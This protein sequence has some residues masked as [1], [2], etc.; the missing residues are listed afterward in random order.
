M[1]DPRSPLQIAEQGYFFA[2]GSYVEHEGAT[3]HAG[4]MFVQYQIPAARTQPL[5]IVMIHGGS[6][7]GTNFLGTPDGRPGWADYFLREGYAVYV[8][9]QPG[10]ARS[11]YYPAIY[12]NTRRQTVAAAERRF[13]APA[14]TKLWPQAHLHTQ[15]PGTGQ[16]G[17]PVFDQFFASQVESIDNGELTERLAR[18]AGVSLFER[19]GAAILLTHSQSGPFG[20]AI[21][22]A[23]PQ[24]VKAILSIEPNGPP[25]HELD[26]LGAPQWFEDAART[27]TW[28][29]TRVPLTYDPPANDPAALRFVK[30]AAADAPGLARCWL[31]AEPARKLPR[32][33]GIPI[34]ILTSEASYH[35]AY[36]HG[37]SR[38][39]TQ[40][41][42]AHTFLR[43]PDIGIR[44][45]GHM[46]MLEKNNLEIA[47]V[48]QRWLVEQGIVT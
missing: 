27:R 2:G 7:T 12:G 15:W 28:G 16:R 31:Q 47:A 43:L 42:V 1:A 32:L 18:D 8:V 46:M 37:T 14:V 48:L 24:R 13:T 45:N 40:A 6:Q 25:V 11:G 19:I 10:R 5:P 34:L 23:C 33:S 3:V 30:Q 35:A 36:D 41:G 4:Q 29:I 44:G 26:L 39:L 20:W 22:D 21:A 38:F 9:D 17:D